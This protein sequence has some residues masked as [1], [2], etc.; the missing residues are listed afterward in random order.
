MYNLKKKFY[1]LI[2]LEGQPDLFAG[3]QVIQLVHF[4]CAGV[5]LSPCSFLFENVVLI[6]IAIAC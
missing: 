4:P 1:L 3:E 5:S 6:N 2:I